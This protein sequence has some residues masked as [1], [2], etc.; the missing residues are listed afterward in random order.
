M[1]SVMGISSPEGVFGRMTLFPQVCLL[2]LSSFC[3]RVQYI[4]IAPVSIFHLSFINDIVIFTNGSQSCLQWLMDVLHH[5]DTVLGQLISQAN[6][7][8]YIRSSASTSNQ[9]IVHSVI[10]FQRCQLLLTYLGCLVFRGCLKI[11][12]FDDMV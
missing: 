1:G 7:S 9:A 6:T 8:F 5:Y 4:S 2:L 10:G 12:H 11:S 3:L